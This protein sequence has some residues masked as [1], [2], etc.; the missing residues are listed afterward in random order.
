[1]R[2]RARR[3]SCLERDVGH[4]L[5]H[6]G[7]ALPRALAKEAQADIEGSAAPVL[8]RQ[9][10]TAGEKRICRWRTS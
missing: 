2:A 3:A 8:T 10:S 6:L 7:E 9:A 4:L 5:A 1:M